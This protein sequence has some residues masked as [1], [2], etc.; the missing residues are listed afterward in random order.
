MCIMSFYV[1]SMWR[2]FTP[3]NEY[4]LAVK[5]IDTLDKL[6]TFLK[7]IKYN[8][9]LK[10]YWDTPEEVINNGS[11]D[12]DGYA[13]LALD[14][15]V[16]IQKR[17]NVYF[18]IYS[19]YYIK[20]SVLKRSGHAVAVFPYKDKLAVISNNNLLTGYNTYEDIGH[21]YYPEGLKSMTIV[22][23]NGKVI[24]NKHNWFKNF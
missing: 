15:L 9:E 21:K 5:D 17:S 8:L 3:T 11:C 4:L 7:D 10:D 22:D 20:N 16:R 18:V 6:V 24:L 1:K 14:I 19:G 2:K 13:R 23:E 12:C